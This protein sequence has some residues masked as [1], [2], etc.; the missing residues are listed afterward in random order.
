MVVAPSASQSPAW[1]AASSAVLGE[2]APEK[3]LQLAFYRDLILT[4]NQKFNLT[5]LRTGEAV[6][7]RLILESIRLVECIRGRIEQPLDGLSLID[8][9]AGAGIPGIPISILDPGVEVLMVEAT[10]KKARFIQEVIAQLDLPNA[11][12]EHGRAE[13]LARSSEHREAFDIAAARAVGPLSTLLELSLPFLKLGGKGF[14]PKGVLDTMEVSQAKAGSVELGA[15]VAAILALPEIA[16]CPFTQVV[17]ADKIEHI[18]ARYP[19]RA[20]IPAR[21]PLKG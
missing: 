16:G 3:A 21:E 18:Q 10:G 20:G 4:W 8:I 13:E 7:S 1:H 14:F 19:R 15:N 6:D 9:G 17:V 11:R 2:L 12:V 5:G